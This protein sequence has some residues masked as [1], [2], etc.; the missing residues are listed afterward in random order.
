[1]AI[2][3]SWIIQTGRSIWTQI[4]Q[5]MM[6]Q[7]APRNGR[8]EYQRP[9]SEFRHRIDGIYSPQPNRYRLYVGWS[10]PWAH[11]TL[12]VRALKGLENSIDIT[13]LRGDAN[14][15]GWALPEPEHGCKTLAQLYRLANP[16]YTGRS[17][18]PMLWD[19]Q[20]NS[21]VNNESAEIVEIL[22]SEF[23]DHATH[24]ELDLSPV[25]LQD[26]LD[27]WN[28]VI[29]QTVNNGV[30]RCGFAQTQTAYDKAH[31]ELFAT[32]DRIE[33][34]LAT[35][36]YLCGDLLTLADVRLFTTLIRF[37][38][39]YHTLFKCNRRRIQDY[40]Q[41]QAYV[42]KIYHLPGVTQTCDF[43]TILQDYYG[44]LFPL[45]PGGIVPK[46]PDMSYLVARGD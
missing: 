2:P 5:V 41:I 40:P 22:N 15:G 16:G 8:G 38:L 37:D 29:Y 34:S 23:N 6:S 43:A 26:S 33:D 27:R 25:A 42:Q 36:N 45:N 1:M 14:A 39:V 10:C 44:N 11:R 24:P 20:T 13:I 32:L 31:T 18:V 12:V 28:E 4:W 30:Y 35:Q 3:P 46:L 21:I 19:T 9:Q 17:T 7:L